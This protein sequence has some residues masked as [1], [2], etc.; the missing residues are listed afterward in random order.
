MIL[1]LLLGFPLLMVLLKIPA[2]LDTN[3]LY[4]LTNTLLPEYLKNTGVLVIGVSLVALVFGVG[5]AWLVTAF[6]FPLRRHLEWLLI[7]PLAIPAF[8]GAIAY[9]G[10]LDYAGP[11]RIFLRQSAVFQDV[12]LDIMNLYGVIFVMASV[13]YPYVY[14][15]CRAAFLIQSGSLIEASRTLGLGMSRT[16]FRV[17]LPVTWP[18][19]VAGLSLIV[20]EVLNDYGTVSYF[21]V[22]TFTTGIFKSWLSLGDL[23]SA[24][25]LSGVLILFVLLLLLV[26]EWSRG[27]KR[28]VTEHQERE[29]SRVRLAGASKWGILALVSVPFLV[30]F[31][32]PVFQMLFWLVLTADKLNVKK[33]FSIL[34]NTVGL[35]V[36]AGLLLMAVSLLMAYAHRIL[37]LGKF[38]KY[39]SKITLLGYALPG[40]VTAI[41]IITMLLLV[42]SSLV[43]YGIFGILFGYQ[44]RFFAVGYQT[45][46]S[47]FKKIPD[48]AD[49]AALTMGSG[50]LRNLFRIHIPLLKTSLISGFILVL[51]DV[52]KELP[53]TLI[54]RPF[55]FETL[56]TNA[57]QY[58][59]D[60]MA[61]ESAAASL[62]IIFVGLVP[63]YLLNKWLIKQ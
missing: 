63:V 29:L 8:I 27:R 40:A 12:N 36:V 4:H 19:I 15:T 57:F 53:I 56:A 42:D 26:E 30:G 25:F 49:E 20:M 58:A 14:L 47:G 32:I 33:L 44:I 43:Y 17:I 28:F 7:M 16:F 9:S 50:P 41:G 54:L 1:S 22:P 31:L 23:P 24:I 21:G 6:D 34:I 2:T 13:L 59:K 39:L 3:T 45:L 61:P 10:F 46:E 60:E 62:L 11:L 5:S 52:A 38:W 18:A 51:V 48:S 55:N 37:K 35:A